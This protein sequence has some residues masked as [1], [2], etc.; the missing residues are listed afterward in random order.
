MNHCNG[1]REYRFVPLREIMSC[2]FGTEVYNLDIHLT[3]FV[4]WW[5]HINAYISL[6]YSFQEI[7]Y[8]SRLEEAFAER[9][10]SLP[11]KVTWTCM[12][13]SACCNEMTVRMCRENTRPCLF[14]LKKNIAGKTVYNSCRSN[15][16]YEAV[17]HLPERQKKRHIS[18]VSDP[19]TNDKK[20]LFMCP[21]KLHPITSNVYIRHTFNR[22]KS[23]DKQN[24]LNYKKW[25]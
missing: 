9:S 22:N 21:E 4:F 25:L 2:L 12:C 18:E 6:L 5:F 15:A 24:Y 20:N 3:P 11:S 16:G 8:C 23:F 14:I 7:A 17:D 10:L 13:V 19:S 1:C